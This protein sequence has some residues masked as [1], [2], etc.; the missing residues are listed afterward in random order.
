VASIVK[1]SRVKKVTDRR[2]GEAR[3]REV[4][5]WR[6]RY[7]DDA[8]KE[9]ARHFDRK[10][11]AQKWLDEQTASLVAGK[12]VAPKTAK[13][14]VGEWCDTW[15]QG[16]ATRRESTVRQARVHVRQIKAEFGGMRL[17]VV[18]PSHVKAWCARLLR[19]GGE[20]G[21]PLSQSYVYALHGRLAQIMADAVHDGIVPQRAFVATTEQLWA[22]HEAMPD[23]IRAAV[24]LGAFAGLRA[25]EACGLR[26]ADVDFM[27]GVVTP[28][29]QFPAEPLK[30]KF[31]KTPVPA[32]RSLALQLSAHLAQWPGETVLTGVDG[33]QLSTWALERA[34]RTARAKVRACGKCQVVQARAGRSFKCE[35]CGAADSEPGL[36][37]GFR[38][39]DLRHYADGWVMRPAV[40]FPLA[41]AAELVLQSA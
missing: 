28:A 18:R 12:H 40:T 15:L 31:S 38:H 19:E 10:V 21:E 6:A 29:V 5:Y 20:G 32:G 41:G 35:A 33:G 25:A 8:G 4:E 11:D 37:E 24:L 17:S 26:V 36:P 16:Y 13:T 23:R 34:V 1:R 7:R 27:R 30:T 3:E 39:H 2:T 14:T 22:L 9:H